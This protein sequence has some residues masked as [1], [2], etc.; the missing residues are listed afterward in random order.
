MLKTLTTQ[1]LLALFAAGWLI[2]NFPL[3]Q[4]W[5]GS[6]LALCGWWAL[7]TEAPAP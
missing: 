1:R 4:L 7:R 6:V 2:F 3:Q 5:S